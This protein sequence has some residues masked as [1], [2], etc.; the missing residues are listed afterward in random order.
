MTELALPRPATAWGRR[1]AAALAVLALVTALT[2]F[3]SLLT[4]AMAIGPATV[5]AVL[6]DGAGDLGQRA[7]I[8]DLRLPR[9]LLGLLVGAA[10]GMGG[11][12]LQ[13]LFRNPLADPTLVGVSGGAAFAAVSAIVLGD[14]LLATAPWLAPWSRWFIAFAAFLGAVAAALC[15]LGLGR[16]VATTM[17]LAGIGVNALAMAGIGLL[18]YAAND[19]QLRDI[20]FWN[21]GSV[22][23]ASWPAVAVVAPLVLAAAAVIL[24]CARGLDALTLG[25]RAA[26]HLGVPVERLGLVVVGGVALAVGAAVSLSGI[27]GFVGL[28]VP[29]LVRLCAGPDHRTLIPG[30]A[31]LGATLMVAADC[32]ART[33]VAPAELPVGLVTALI[34]TPFFLWLIRRRGSAA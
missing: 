33:I 6:V 16:G 27:I 34:G 14:A 32:L 28:V 5:W 4:G 25:D 26:A 15:V 23:G 22:G 17:L 10:L 30:S 19:R 24:S 31:L 21:L 2:A 1:R 8:L 3:A 12:T 29:H 20:T 13:G 9:T 11:A 7:A 18:V